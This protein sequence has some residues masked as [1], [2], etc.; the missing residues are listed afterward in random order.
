M[1]DIVECLYGL[2]L[3]RSFVDNEMRIT[4]VPGGWIYEIPRGI[5]KRVTSQF[6]PYDNE[7]QYK[8]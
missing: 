8:D 1:E 3:H 6:V 2:K 4:R 5:S 7:F